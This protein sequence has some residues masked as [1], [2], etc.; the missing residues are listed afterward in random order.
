MLDYVSVAHIHARSVNQ[1]HYVFNARTDTFSMEQPVN[2]VSPIASPAQTQIPV[3][4]VR[5][6]TTS[7]VKVKS[8]RKTMH[9]LSP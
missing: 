3:S 2:H 6:A 8:Y 4:P 1:H 7:M 9:L 5:L